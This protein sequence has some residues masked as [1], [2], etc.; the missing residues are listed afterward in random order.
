VLTINGHSYVFGSGLPALSAY[1]GFWNDLQQ[2][3]IG[4]ME[5]FNGG[6]SYQPIIDGVL[7]TNYAG[8]G[9]AHYPNPPGPGHDG[10]FQLHIGS[11]TAYYTQAWLTIGAVPGPIVG[12][13]LPAFLLLA[14]FVAFAYRRQTRRA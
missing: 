8:Y 7:A 10:L 11:S 9:D 5:S 3:H 2:V 13:G 4:H 14:A 1:N 6:W 12:T